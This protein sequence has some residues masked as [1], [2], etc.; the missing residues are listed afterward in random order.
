M[1]T[2]IQFRFSSFIGTLRLQATKGNWPLPSKGRKLYKGS[3]LLVISG[4]NVRKFFREAC[5]KRHPINERKVGTGTGISICFFLSR[6]KITGRAHGQ[7]WDRCLCLPSRVRASR[8]NRL[9]QRSGRQS[10]MER[11]QAA[12]FW[13]HL[14]QKEEGFLTSESQQTERRAWGPLGVGT[15][16]V[17][18]PLGLPFTFHKHLTTLERMVS[19]A[20]KRRC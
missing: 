16:P 10:G 17:Q 13:W 20:T 4:R 12:R 15:P 19:L 3:E 1:F 11:S 6:R 9:G 18:C 5:R 7:P 8:Q 2:F 14:A